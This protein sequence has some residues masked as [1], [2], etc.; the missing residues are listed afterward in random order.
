[1]LR[2]HRQFCKRCRCTC[3][4]T[5]AAGDRR[6]EELHAFGSSGW[7]KPQPAR[8]II[9]KSPERAGWTMRMSSR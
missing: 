9:C 7:I 6:R 4:D 3:D 1:M 5:R 8:Q 2:D